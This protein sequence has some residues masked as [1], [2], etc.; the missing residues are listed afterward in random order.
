MARF[1]FDQDTIAQKDILIDRLAAAS[2]FSPKP[3]YK[4]R[5]RKAN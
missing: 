4:G 5:H 1:E 3:E 2:L